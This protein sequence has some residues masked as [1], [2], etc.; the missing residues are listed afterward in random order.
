MNIKTKKQNSDGIV[1]LETSGTIKEI[2]IKEDLLKE[3]ETKIEVCFRGKNSSGIV[4]FSP[5]EM[6]NL[7]QDIAPKL[8][9]IKNVK[10][11]KFQK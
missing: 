11:K 4:E 10:V 6:E 1:R 5:R 3:K 2:L 9:L 7:I 8:E